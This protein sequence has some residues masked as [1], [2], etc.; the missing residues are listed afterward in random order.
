[1]KPFAYVFSSWMFFLSTS[2]TI[3]V[4]AF[5][6]TPGKDG[7]ATITGSVNTYYR[8]SSSGASGSAVTV[9]AINGSGATSPIAAGDMVLIVQMQGA[10][11]NSANTNQY[12]DGAGSGATA[13][14]DV[15]G[16]PNYAG[17]FLSN[18]NL[19]AGKYEF[20]VAASALSGGSFN[21]TAP[22]INT[23][24]NGTNRRYQVIRV[25]QYANATI[26]AGG[27]TAPAWDGNSGGIVAIDLAGQLTLSG[28]ID[29][30]GRGFRGGGVRNVAAQT[31]PQPSDYVGLVN[32]AKG[33]AKGEGIAATPYR[34]Y[35]TILGLSAI[36]TD[37]LP[38]GDLMRGAPANAGGGGNQHNNG[39]GGG[40]NGGAG[41]R[42]GAG[43]NG[44]VW[45]ADGP[46]RG[47]MGGSPTTASS[48][49]TRMFFGGGGGAGDVG[50]NSSTNPQG[51]GGAGGGMIFVRGKNIVGSGSFN[52][53]GAQGTDL[54]STDAT[55]G[56]GAGGSI[57]VSIQS[58][59]LGAVSLTAVGGRGGNNNL[60]TGTP[61][62]DGPGGGGG[63]GV[64]YS[65]VP[66][67]TTLT[68]GGAGTLTT[69][70]TSPGDPSG[71]YYA[72]AGFNGLTG[73]FGTPILTI[74]A[75]SGAECLAAL[76]V[77]KTVS[78]LCDPSNGST[79]PKNIPGA[80]V[81]WKISVANAVGSGSSATLNQVADTL[82]ANLNFEPNFI[83]GAGVGVVCSSASGAPVSAAGNGF[84]FDLL[85]DSR[86]GTYPKFFTS[87]N[88]A[89]SA[90]LSGSSI[91]LNYLTAMPIEGS[92]AAGELKAGETA[93]F[94]F[95]SVV[96]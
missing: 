5:C 44:N 24:L 1:M 10:D 87:A 72:T 57:L 74:G 66:V 6:G 64:V 50:G 27:V 58:G 92:Y 94:E 75:Q 81:R 67:S 54:V 45:N 61:E 16:G 93:T 22:L 38:G 37:A 48:T 21:L 89:D 62:Q 43:W 29:V 77:T 35:S 23:Y 2:V 46:I 71:H 49:P 17:G 34:T 95:N 80:V 91:T 3:P 83:T 15:Y 8:G 84:R 40:G 26:G 36:G 19:I 85:G 9:G 39:G 82:D 18:T 76:T 65:N 60:G 28:N 12:G 31:N 32:T 20:A 13:N 52:A 51:S 25:P 73:T 53:S 7:T 11:I 56:G 96:K 4:Y 63:G 86:P 14:S 68:A 33:G 59:T 70:S 88:D 41:G 55:G 78:L 79:N 69:G 30:S 47:G 90:N 42:G